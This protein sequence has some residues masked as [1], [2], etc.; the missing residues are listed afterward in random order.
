MTAFI[1][2][3][4]IIIAGCQSQLTDSEANPPADIDREVAKPQ[5]IASYIQEREPGA[6]HIVDPNTSETILTIL[7]HELGYELDNELYKKEIE[8]LAKK[9][10]RGTEGKPG[11]DRRMLL[12]R[13]DEQGNIVKGSPLILLKESD[14]V[15]SIMAASAVGGT[16]ELPIVIS[17]SGYN[18]AEISLMNETILASYTTYFN[19]TDANRNKNIELSAKAIHNVIVGNGDQ[20]SF[21]TVVG[22]RDEASGYRPAPEIINGELVM[23]IGGGVCQT[24]STLFNAVDQMPVTYIEWHHHS[25]E[26]GY[27]PKGKDA[28]VSYGGLDF[29]FRNTTGVPFL[30]KA[31]Y[32]DSFL[33]IEIR[34]AEKYRETLAK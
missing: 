31:I 25:R 3:C 14:L 12:D 18:P 29:R 9:L 33:T 28:T 30:V 5:I 26:I 11:Y 20:F 7:P 34:T 27:V 19:K 16:V 1:L 10:A 17:E 32:G 8:L 24:S 23:G 4:L 6:V 15:E 2:F 13:L 22:P 21:N